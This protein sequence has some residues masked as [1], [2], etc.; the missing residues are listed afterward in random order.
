MAQSNQ[1]TARSVAVFVVLTVLPLALAALGT[2]L[3][4]W[5]AVDASLAV[6]LRVAAIA[7]AA[8]LAILLAIKAVRDHRSSLTTREARYD[9]VR[10]LHDR[11]GPALDQ[12][13]ELALLEPEE[14]LVRA[15][16]LRT[17]AS[18]CCS[19][20]VA[21]TP[22]SKD[23]RAVVFE[24]RPPGVVEPLAHFGRNDVPRSFH[25]ATPAGQE[26]YDYLASGRNPTGELYEDVQKGAPA[27]YVGDAARYRTFIRTPIRGGEIVFGMLTV[28]APKAGTLTAGDVRLAEL[29]AAQLG[30]AFAVAAS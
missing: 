13:T 10:E 3:G 16:V 30:T 8:L 14:S 27:H 4:L 5:A 9:A 24:F 15:Q 17:I 18:N 28:D 26:I 20:L 12:I 1:R 29:I 19:A 2:S 22:E 25:L 11:I 21:M 6:P 7:C 23:V